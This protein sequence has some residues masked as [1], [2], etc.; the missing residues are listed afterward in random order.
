VIVCVDNN[1]SADTLLVYIFVIIQCAVNFRGNKFGGINMSKQDNKRRLNLIATISM[2]VF[3]TAMLTGEAFAQSKAKS[4][5]TVIVT[6]SSIKR[7]LETGALP[8]LVVTKEEIEREGISSTEQ[9]SMFL[10]SSSTGADNLASNADVVAGSQRGLN[11]VSAANLRGQGA[12]GTLVLFNGRRVAANGLSGSVVD[13]N[14]IPL[15]AI[16]RVDVLRDGAS[17]IYGTDAIG[18]VINYITKKNYQGLNAQA[19]TDITEHGGGEIMRYSLTGGFGNLDTQNFNIMA[20]L[21]YSDNKALDGADREWINGFQPEKGLSI[22]TRG[23]PFATIFPLNASTASGANP[24]G[25]LF[26]G[27]AG[28]GVNPL[29]PFITGSTTV[30]ANGGVNILDLPNGAGCDTYDGMQAYDAALWNA[31][32][33]QFACAW[34]TGRAVVIQQ[35]ITKKNLITRGIYR[36]GEHELSAE[37]MLSESVAAKRFSNPQ[38]SSGTLTST[39]GNSNSNFLYPLNAT[40]KTTYDGIFNAL[41]SYSTAWASFLAPRYGLP[42]AYRWRCIECGQRE[43]TTT[44]KTGRYFLGLDGPMGADWNYR[45]GASTAWSESSSLLGS[46]YY[47]RHTNTPNGTGASNVGKVGIVDVLNS[48]IINVF[49]PA[50]QSQTAE[51]MAA[52]ESASA[53]GVTLYGGKYEVTQVDGSASGPL[54]KLPG[55]TAYAAVGFDLREEKYNFN[56]DARAIQPEIFLA[57]FDNSNALKG[58]SRT[59]NAA[60]AELMLP[61][62]KNMEVTLAGRVDQ[63]SGFGTSVNPKYSFRYRPVDPIILRAS[64]NTGF[65]VPSFNQIFNGTS[66]STFVGSTL[67]DPATCPGGVPSAATGC[68]AVHPEIVSGGNVNLSP[69]EA[70]QY[71]YGL[72]FEPIKNYSIS[73]DYWHIEKSNSIYSFLSDIGLAKMAANYS[74]FEDRFFRD[75][76][77]TLLGIDARYGNAGGSITEGLEI[78]LKARGNIFGGKW[79]ASMDGTKLLTKK[80][81]L[82]DSSPWGASEIGLFTLAGDL[83]LDWKH[84]INLNYSKGNW[85]TSV[86]QV[87]RNGYTNGKLPGVANGTVVPPEVV[88]EVDDYTIYNASV[89]YKGFKNFKITGG[90][91]NLLDQD[92]P[93][94]ITYDSNGGS[95]GNW[96]PRVADPRGRSFTLLLDYK[97]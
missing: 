30:R 44:S 53:K 76:S 67:A 72:I 2:G 88:V 59:I 77:G 16:E 85:S 20:S 66:I 37:V 35:P 25:S 5:D 17:A 29:A 78:G 43:I 80:S 64:Y 86:S 42:I 15:S 95:G 65:R 93:F 51:A 8:I 69:E 79:S 81:R 47:Y 46:G 27:T 10:S 31:P 83:G 22:D 21:S 82:L 94:A 28:S 62:M 70:E 96:E 24:T 40:T 23:T 87:F 97:F 33:S 58:K 4:T 45:V 55:G 50:G 7:K 56:G 34:D 19:F 75:G 52:L 73:V 92:P 89:T 39:N 68:A 38:F 84:N 9:L 63:Y 6:G 61:I 12:G 41:S 49:L 18:G 54:F 1:S 14:Q 36:M 48:G 90:I 71:T 26:G 32:S 74:L 57:P 91:R 13:L 60:Y 11:G 3:A